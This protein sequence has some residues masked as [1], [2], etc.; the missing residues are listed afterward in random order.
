MIRGQGAGRRGLVAVLL[1]GSLM[2]GALAGCSVVPQGPEQSEETTVD[3]GGVAD[4]VTKAVP[5]V[6]EV[7]DSSRSRNGFGYRFSAGLVT[8]SAEPLTPA[9]LDAVV[10]AIWQRLPWEPNTIKLT[11]GTDADAGHEAVDLRAAA[12]AL[13]PLRVRDA[14]Q[15]GVSLTGMASR[16]GAWTAP[17]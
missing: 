1:A 10:K 16:Y 8:D 12:D 5:R 2:G 4:A 15:A 14:G 7:R 11:A 17:E 3:Y 6:V 9:E 13:D